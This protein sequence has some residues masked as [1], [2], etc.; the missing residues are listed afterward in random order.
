VKFLIITEV[1]KGIELEVSAKS[2]AFA[3]LKSNL[4]VIFGGSLGVS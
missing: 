1:W 2:V 3:A 4:I